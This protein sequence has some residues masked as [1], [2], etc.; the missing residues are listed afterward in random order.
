MLQYFPPAIDECC[1]K[2][3]TNV[4]VGIFI[5][6]SICKGAFLMH[7]SNVA[8]VAFPCCSSFFH[9]LNMLLLHVAGGDEPSDGSDVRALVVPNLKTVQGCFFYSRTKGEGNNHRSCPMMS[10]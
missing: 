4:A 10:V 7:I 2:Y 8:H 6:D 3:G 1:K 5:L 9:M